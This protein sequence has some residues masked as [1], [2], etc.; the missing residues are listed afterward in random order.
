MV[1]PPMLMAAIPGDFV[2]P[3]HNEAFNLV[4]FEKNA[5]DE[6]NKCTNHKCTTHTCWS[7]DVDDLIILVEAFDNSLGS[8]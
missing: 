1:V 6:H 2:D 3:N 5:I 4:K 7:S 8:P